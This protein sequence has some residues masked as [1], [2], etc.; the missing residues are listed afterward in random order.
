MEDMRDIKI[1]TGTI[2]L[3]DPFLFGL[4]FR[5][6]VV[7]MT[8]HRNDGSVGFILNKKMDI[9]V[10]DLIPNFPDFEGMMYFGGPV[11]Q[12]TV[13][14]IHNAGDL[15]ENSIEIC[16][17]VFWGGDF[18][19]LK[20]LIDQELIKP[21]NIRFFVGYSG[22]SEGQLM[23]E[24][25]EGSWILDKMDANY[26]FKDYKK[27]LWKVVLENKGNAFSVIA[28]FPDYPSYN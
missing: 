25:R 18:Q 21:K 13:H 22:W 9:K 4:P 16:P 28:H 27:D 7:L 20:F 12:D 15:L 6:S 14:Y 5:R 1:E 11:D 24:I 23:D 26:A 3:A 10:S 19:T 2:L 8:E 17:G